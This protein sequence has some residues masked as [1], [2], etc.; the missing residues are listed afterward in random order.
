MSKE[1]SS[2]F[3]FLWNVLFMPLAYF[4][5]G[6]FLLKFHY[7]PKAHFYLSSFNIFPLDIHCLKSLMGT[8]VKVCLLFL[9]VNK[10]MQTW[11]YKS[12]ISNEFDI[13]RGLGVVYWVYWV[14][15]MKD[16]SD[17]L[18]NNFENF[19]EPW[20]KN[21]S[22][23]KEGKMFNRT[24]KLSLFK[25]LFLFLNS[26]ESIVKEMIKFLLW[27]TTCK[28]IFKVSRTLVLIVVKENLQILMDSQQ[29]F[30]YLPAEFDS[31]INGWTW[32][33]LE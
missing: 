23:S 13:N 4:K 8:Q 9:H 15:S 28:D 30:D 22:W 5:A 2:G 27:L 21:F 6:Q 31:W 29:L 24:K 17:T 14:V 18:V 19:L 1:L 3:A 32:F 16:N 25:H 33:F 7:F 20:K 12:E 10:K 26:N 11:P